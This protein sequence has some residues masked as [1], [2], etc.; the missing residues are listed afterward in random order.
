MKLR[1]MP[2]ERAKRWLL[3]LALDD[4]SLANSGLDCFR[5]EMSRS[6]PSCNS[7]LWA[8]STGKSNRCRLLL[9]RSALKHKLT[10][11]QLNPLIFIPL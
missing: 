9:Q 5:R 1:S 10:V 2:V 8:F 7:V 6:G 11:A 4:C 3:L